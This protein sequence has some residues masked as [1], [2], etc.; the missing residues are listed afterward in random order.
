WATAAGWV[1]TAVA[2]E[3]PTLARQMWTELIADFQA[4]GICECVTPDYR[5]L[6]SYVASATNPLAAARRWLLPA[7]ARR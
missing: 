6:P 3:R 5:Q 1:M 7:P 4:G 2:R